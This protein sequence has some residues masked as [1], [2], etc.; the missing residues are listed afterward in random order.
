MGLLAHHRG[1]VTATRL[2]LLHLIWNTFA[3]L[4]RLAKLRAE[5]L[6]GRRAQ[7]GEL[8]GMCCRGLLQHTRWAVVH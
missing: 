2:A 4:C 3:G 8:H 7:L 6:C 5:T 1:L